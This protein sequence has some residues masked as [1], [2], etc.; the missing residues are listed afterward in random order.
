MGLLDLPKAY[1]AKQWLVKSVKKFAAALLVGSWFGSRG[2]IDVVGS[3]IGSS[4]F[5]TS[6]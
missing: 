4:K 2:A 1:H 5:L 6:S 3:I